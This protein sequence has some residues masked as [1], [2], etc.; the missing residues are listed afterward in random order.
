M[1][2]GIDAE[3]FPCNPDA[4]FMSTLALRKF[5]ASEF[6]NVAYMEPF[7]LKEFTISKNKKKILG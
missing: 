7:Y 1:V 6:E 5:N 3:L 4:R 2:S